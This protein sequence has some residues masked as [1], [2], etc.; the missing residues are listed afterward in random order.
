MKQRHGS[1]RHDYLHLPECGYQNTWTRDEILRRDK[2][3]I[4]RG[5]QEDRYSLPCKN[6]AAP[7]CSGRYIIAIACDRQ[8]T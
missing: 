4:Y 5:V 1:A 6:P 8:R 3:E 7:A 2:R